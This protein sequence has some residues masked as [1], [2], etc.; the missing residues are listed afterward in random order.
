MLC[1]TVRE[2]KD[3]IFLY[4]LDG[5]LS[6]KTYRDQWV[7]LAKR[8][9]VRGTF[10]YQTW[11]LHLN[12]HLK[13]N[14]KFWKLLEISGRKRGGIAGSKIDRNTGWLYS[15]AKEKHFCMRC[16]ASKHNAW[17]RKRHKVCPFKDF[18]LCSPLMFTKLLT[19]IYI[20]SLYSYHLTDILNRQKQ[21]VS[22]IL[23]VSSLQVSGGWIPSKPGAATL[24][25]W[26]FA[27]VL[28]ALFSSPSSWVTKALEESCPAA[29]VSG[30]ETGGNILISVKPLSK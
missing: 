28:I 12:K 24:L 19:H 17:R 21:S 11:N 4:S 7:L 13:D 27:S 30:K 6:W 8:F 2:T 23:P 29:K 22:F 16:Y 14:N 10:M 15:Q 20:M 5:L 25:L 3:Q 9:W 18:N 26:T 1:I